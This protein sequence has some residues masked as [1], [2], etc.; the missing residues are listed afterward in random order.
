MQENEASSQP[1]PVQ[2]KPHQKNLDTSTRSINNDPIN[3][4]KHK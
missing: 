3:T 2:L 4:K 1:R